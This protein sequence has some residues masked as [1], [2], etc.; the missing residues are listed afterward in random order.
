MHAVYCSAKYISNFLYASAS[1]SLKVTSTVCTY[2]LGSSSRLN[3]VSVYFCSTVKVNM[4]QIRKK[5]CN[6]ERRKK[7]EER[8]K[9]KGEVTKEKKETKGD[10]KKGKKEGKSE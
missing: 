7:R 2:F 6:L 8:R 3:P 5:K 9:K 1:A 10:E 4:I